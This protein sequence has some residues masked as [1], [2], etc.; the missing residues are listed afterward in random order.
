[1]KSGVPQRSTL[2]P[3][4][5][6]IFINDICDSVS[7]SKCLLFDGDLKVYHNINYVRD[8][9]LLQSDINSMQNWCFENCMTL[10]VGKTTIISFTR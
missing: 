1:V 4:L 2:G 5:F 7:Y 3:L 6:N 9:K 8:C 10:N